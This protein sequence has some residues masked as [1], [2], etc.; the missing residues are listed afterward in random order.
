M[1]V[2]ADTSPINYLLLIDEIQLLPSLYGTIIVPRAVA[3]E[4]RDSDAPE[5]IKRWIASPPVWFHEHILSGPPRS[6]IP[7]LDKGET[8]A[9]ELA[10]T[11]K[12]E[13]LLIDESKGRTAAI[14]L[15]LQV[16]GT[17][18]ILIEAAVAGLVDLEESLD[19]LE[20]TNFRITRALRN[21]A[22]RIAKGHP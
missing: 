9:L 15:N 6:G 5:I 22:L 18:G 3:T 4:L 2:V 19:K 12:S 1:V 8:E 13:L 17:V 16:R 10:L 14:A 7:E 11:L 20:A 21:Q